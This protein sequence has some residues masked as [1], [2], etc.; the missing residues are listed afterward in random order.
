MEN[1]CKGVPA[2]MLGQPL[3]EVTG[4]VWWSFCHLTH[5]GQRPSVEGVRG[6]KNPCVAQD[7]T[8]RNGLCVGCDDGHPLHRVGDV[9]KGVL[10]VWGLEDEEHPGQTPF[11]VPLSPSALEVPLV[12]PQ[13]GAGTL[14]RRGPPLE[15]QQVRTAPAHVLQREG[16]VGVNDVGGPVIAVADAGAGGGQQVEQVVVRGAGDLGGQGGGETGDAGMVPKLRGEGA[17]RGPCVDAGVRV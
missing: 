5:Q 8:L 17:Q 7:A 3:Q 15:L 2:A 14:R 16:G 13:A 4:T 11:V 6:R 10:V 1:S 9:E 12:G